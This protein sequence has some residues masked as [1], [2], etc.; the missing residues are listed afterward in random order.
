MRKYIC[1]EDAVG[2]DAEIAAQ[3]WRKFLALNASVVTELFAG[4]LKSTVVCPRCERV[5][6]SFDPYTMLSLPL[7]TNSTRNVVVLLQRSPYDCNAARRRTVPWIGELVDGRGAPVYQL[8][9]LTPHESDPF[10]EKPWEGLGFVLPKTANVA[11]L[12]SSI[13]RESGI[14][15]DR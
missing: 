4:Q 9:G 6:V 11:E 5:S 12:R 10:R 14:P 2:P 15:A 1:E 3:Y 13:S 8:A 7:P